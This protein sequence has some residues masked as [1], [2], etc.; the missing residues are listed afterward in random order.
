MTDS[1]GIMCS[2]HYSYLVQYRYHPALTHVY[3]YI[4]M[5]M[6]YS[7]QCMT[8]HVHAHVHIVVQTVNS[9]EKNICIYIHVYTRM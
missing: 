9:E 4:Y 3:I 8:V 5:Y 1:H 2:N 7:V 6:Y